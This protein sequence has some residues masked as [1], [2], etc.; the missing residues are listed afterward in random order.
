MQLT[1]QDA[2]KSG[3][4]AHR[5]KNYTKADALYTAILKNSPTHPDAN[6]NMGVLAVDV[7]RPEKAIIFFQTAIASD[8]DR[9][10]FWVSY[11]DAL[12]ILN[13][14]DEAV[15]ALRLAR[16]RIGDD[17]CFATLASKLPKSPQAEV[18]FSSKEEKNQTF[19]SDFSLNNQHPTPDAVNAVVE[20]YK[21]GEY[22]E[23]L[24][25]T[26][27]LLKTHP[28]SVV[29]LNMAGAL[30]AKL[31]RSDDAISFYESAVKIDAVAEVLNNLGNVLK[32]TGR[33]NDAKVAY[34][35]AI[36]KN[37]DFLEAH[38]NLG[39]LLISMGDLKSAIISLDR[40]GGQS[41]VAKALECLL[42][43]GDYDEFLKRVKKYDR[44]DPANIRVAAASAYASH[45]LDI[46]DPYSFCP[47]PLAMI[48]FSHISDHIDGTAN[49]LLETLNELN[50]R[51]SVWEPQGQTTTGG[52]QTG[53]S[54]FQYPSEKL[55]VLKEIVCAE[56]DKYQS[57]F[58][59]TDCLLV[60]KWPREYRFA[61]W[62]VR[63]LQAGFQDRHIHAGGWVSGVI[64]LK[65]IHAPLD[66]EGAIKF[67]LNG[68]KFTDAQP[69]PEFIYQPKDGDIVLFPSSLF[70]ETVPVLQAAERCVV[71]FDLL[72][73]R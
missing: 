63:L 42:A 52:F 68:Y 26:E 65:T 28:R 64:Y 43:L 61:S 2:L 51:S 31:K 46:A 60:H 34:E 62:Y 54:L 49:F 15:T 50:T 66:S 69:D 19:G 5:E 7:G 72:P 38:G 36:L 59:E 33:F 4:S 57:Q 18:V 1:I 32:D 21:I 14:H 23:A 22:A 20:K 53:T 73:A 6:H 13:K 25:D 45:K 55:N 8:M 24:L 39:T 10:Q 48:S 35:R 3:I 41:S 27:Y 12:I 30:C 56:L 67:R 70:H 29:L 71:A 9:A 11:I 47:N 37:P 40:S 44:D 16:N 58:R 17:K